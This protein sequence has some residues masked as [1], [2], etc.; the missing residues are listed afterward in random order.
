[1]NPGK[2]YIVGAGLSGLSAA[3]ALAAKGV[4][5]EIIEA[6]G[7]AGGRCRSY[8][9]PALDCVIDNGNHLILSGNWAVHDYLRAIGSEI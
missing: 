6:A 9:E 2:V 8:Y 4:R 5:V 1:M 7:T 3:V